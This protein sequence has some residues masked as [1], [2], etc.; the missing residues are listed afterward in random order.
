MK[1]TVGQK[2]FFWITM[3][4]TFSLPIAAGNIFD[5]IISILKIGS[6]S[7]NLIEINILI[8]AGI[9]LI[10]NSSKNKNR[11]LFQ[12]ILFF[13]I[14]FIYIIYAFIGIRKNLKVI[15]EIKMILVPMLL[16][17]VLRNNHNLKKISFNKF[18]YFLICFVSINLGINLIMYFTQSSKIWGY[19]INNLGYFG[20]NY[21]SYLIFIVPMC[22]YVLYT[23]NIKIKKIILLFTLVTSIFFVVQ[24]ESRALFIM[25]LLCTI[26]V[27]FF[28]FNS[29]ESK[30]GNKKKMFLFFIMFSTFIFFLIYMYNT[31]AKVINKLLTMDL[32]SV[33]DSLGTRLYTWNYQVDEIKQN[34]FGEGL[35]YELFGIN[36][37]GNIVSVSNLYVDSY[38][39]TMARKIGIVGLAILC[40]FFLIPVFTLFKLY[41]DNREKIYILA[42]LTYVCMII[43]GTAVSSQLYH[44]RV[45]YTYCWCIIAIATNNYENLMNRKRAI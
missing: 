38:I 5:N 35:G 37:Y 4:I 34:P 33:N 23:G 10:S 13:F 25:A 3:F 28:C 39:L 45:V 1:I 16:Y 21:F 27:I 40:L 41:K 19:T 17:Y 20:G 12:D 8:L 9:T 31:D 24:N 29:K 14:L 43:M 2:T 15:S 18:I 44:G 26:I 32:Y 11:I 22:V 30:F 7:I 36:R 6:G 42:L